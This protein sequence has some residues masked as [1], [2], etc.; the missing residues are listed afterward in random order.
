MSHDD[1]YKHEEPEDTCFDEFPD[2]TPKAFEAITDLEDALAMAIHNATILTEGFQDQPDMAYYYGD[3][4]AISAMVE[5]SQEII[6]SVKERA[7][8]DIKASLP[9]P[10]ELANLGRCLFSTGSD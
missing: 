2:I 10:E 7:W 1:E 4:V 8:D 9:T 3:L 6:A 5:K